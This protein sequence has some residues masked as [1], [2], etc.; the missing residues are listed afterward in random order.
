MKRILAGLASF[1][2]V[3]AVSTEGRAEMTANELLSLYDD[4]D[5]ETREL[6][7]TVIDGNSNGISW[8]NSF[9]DESR[10][11]KAQVYCPPGEFVTDGPGMIKMMRKVVK[12]DQRY[13]T[14]PYG[15]AVMFTYIER[16]PCD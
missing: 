10:G 15:A 4:G 6:L 1:L 7:E 9:L 16:F 3:L 11:S 5:T 13:G 14:L 12:E 8:V 2:V